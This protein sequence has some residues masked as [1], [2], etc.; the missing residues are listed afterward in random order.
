[1]MERPSIQSYDN[2]FPDGTYRP[3]PPF[4]KWSDRQKQVI[5]A[6]HSLKLFNEDIP[7]HYLDYITYHYGE[8]CDVVDFAIFFVSYW[9]RSG[10]ILS[11]DENGIIKIDHNII[12]TK[13]IEWVKIMDYDKLHKRTEHNN[14]YQNFI[15]TIN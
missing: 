1:M 9:S 3:Y 15:Y 10:G 8:F 6:L 11:L 14:L 5:F 13:F 2:K 12:D 4:E 7:M